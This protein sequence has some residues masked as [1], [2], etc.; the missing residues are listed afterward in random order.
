[1]TV[2]SSISEVSITENSPAIF[3]DKKTPE[4]NRIIESFEFTE[5]AISSLFSLKLIIKFPFRSFKEEN[6]KDILNQK[7]QIKVI[8][9][10]LSDEK[11]EK[12]KYI[13]GIIKEV[14]FIAFESESFLFELKVVPPFFQ[15]KLNNAFRSWNN[16]TAKE[17]ITEVINS[18]SKEKINFEFIITASESII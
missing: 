5:D 10:K 4:N 15:T 2:F 12:T 16:T 14:S 3:F 8:Y 17:A 13:T 1:M 11:K 6:L 18:Y 7:I 9:N